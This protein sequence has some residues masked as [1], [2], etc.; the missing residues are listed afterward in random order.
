M[1]DTKLHYLLATMNAHELNRFA[2]F[3]ASPYHNEDE[4]LIRLIGYLVQYYKTKPTEAPD[5]IHIWKNA[6]GTR[7][8]T[9]IQ[10]ARLLSDML[11][12]AESFVS[13]ERMK[14]EGPDDAYYLLDAYNHRGLVKNFSEPYA[15]AVRKLEETPYRDRDYYF[16]TFRL[17]AQ[18]NTFLENRKERTTEKHLTEAVDSLDTFYFINKLRYSA[19]ILHY[20]HF[21]NLDDDFTLLKEMLE[22]LRR[23]PLT[24]VA[25]LYHQVILTLT[26]PGEEEHY[27]KLKDILFKNADKLQVATQREG[28]AFAQNYCIR[29]INSGRPEYQREIFTLYKDALVRGLMYDYGVLNPWDYKNI[30]TIGLRNKDYKWTSN[31]IDK[32]LDKLKKSEQK[33]AYTF[34][35]ARYYFATGKYDKVLKLLQDVEYTD[36]FYLLDAKVTLMKTYYELGEYEPLLSLKESFRILLRRKKL[37]SEQN[38]INYGNFARLTMKLY[39][40]DVK[41][42]VQM[43]SLKKAIESTSNIADRAWILEKYQQL[44]G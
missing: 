2:K 34:N 9:T 29:K 31:F 26:E 18:H 22:H 4:K 1:Q 19:A 23:K 20:K 25:D 38:Q 40:A 5:R 8:F 37:I 35:S 11:K 43:A 15:L 12:K 44:L 42:K 16:H 33:N 24:P 36:V 6:H 32:Y 3:I 41:N 7:T 30:V 17:H 10:Y 13:I 14:Q 27:Y 39:R 21:L 28:F